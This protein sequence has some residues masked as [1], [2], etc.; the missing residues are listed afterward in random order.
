MSDELHDMASLLS[1]LVS[2]PDRAGGRARGNVPKDGEG[3][4][5]RGEG[6]GH[7]RGA[8]RGGTSGRAGRGEI[9]ARRGEEGLVQRR[10]GRAH[11]HEVVAHRAA[12][13]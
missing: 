3:V 13:S 12:Q 6:N 9:G 5:G 7:D 2:I 10:I 8:G 1:I 4:G 11:Q